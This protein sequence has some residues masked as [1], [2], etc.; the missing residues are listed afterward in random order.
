MGSNRPGIAEGEGVV[1]PLDLNQA[2][3]QADL[4]LKEVEPYFCISL[5]GPVSLLP[6]GVSLLGA[7]PSSTQKED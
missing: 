5:R 4:T 3:P 7:G 2:R 6:I 1:R